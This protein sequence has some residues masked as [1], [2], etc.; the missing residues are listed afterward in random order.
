MN[1][2]QMIVAQDARHK[3]D[4]VEVRTCEMKIVQGL[5]QFLT[6]MGDIHQRQTI[7]L[8]PCTKEGLLLLKK[9][10]SWNEIKDGMFLIIN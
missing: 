6:E 9:P 3:Q 8:T 4:V 5:K 7:C 1:I 10:E 2:E